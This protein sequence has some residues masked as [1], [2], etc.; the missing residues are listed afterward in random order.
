V[1]TNPQ[2][3]ETNWKN[4][5]DVESWRATR[6]K[7]LARVWQDNFSPLLMG[8]P[9]SASAPGLLPGQLLSGPVIQDFQREGESLTG[10]L[11][12]KDADAGLDKLPISSQKP[13]S[14]VNLVGKD[15]DG[16]ITFGAEWQRDPWGAKATKW[17]KGKGGT[18][19]VNGLE[20][21]AN[22]E[23]AC[24]LIGGQVHCRTGHQFHVSY[25]CGNRYCPTCGPKGAKELFAKTI[26]PLQL[27]AARL[28]DCGSLECKE[29]YWSRRQQVKDGSGVFVP[30]P[31]WPPPKGSKPARVVAI[32][33]FTMPNYFKGRILGKSELETLRLQF[34]YFN[35]YIKR[36]ARAL[37]RQTGMTRREYG[38]MWCDELGQ[39][40]S[41]VHAHGIYVGPWLP[42][43]NRELSALWSKITGGRAKIIFLKYAE[44]LER[45]LYHALKYPAKYASEEKTSPERAAHLEIIFHRVRRVHALAVFYNME[46]PSDDLEKDSAFSKCPLCAERL[47]VPEFRYL[48]SELVAAGSR[49]VNDIQREKE[50]AFVLAGVAGGGS[51]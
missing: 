51:P 36:F 6:K 4:P 22:R 21:K 15:A 34:Q 2:I 23:I 24:G 50:R 13:W 11:E 25:R 41:N 29:C 14:V 10:Y 43:K 1:S 20:K 9:L 30:V 49:D 47:S 17:K 40:N 7:T 35:K 48:L 46:K 28:M 16:A 27:A 8:I 19:M 32:L 44:S 26:G 38:L 18:L 5:F 39:N 45:A 37:E 33:D 31:H 3:T 42:Q 12:R